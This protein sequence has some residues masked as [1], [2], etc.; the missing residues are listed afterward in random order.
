MYANWRQ[1]MK[2]L[3]ALA[4]KFAELLRTSHADCHLTW[5]AFYTSFMKSLEYLMEAPCFTLE[6]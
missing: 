2:V 6:Q 4:Q 5:Y 1:Q 3:I